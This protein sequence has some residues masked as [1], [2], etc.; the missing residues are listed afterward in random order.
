MSHML[1]GILILITF[2]SY[3]GKSTGKGGLGIWMH[4]LNASIFIENYESSYYTGPAFRFGAG[5][6]AY[7]AYIAADAK[8]YRVIGGECPTVG[9]VGGYTQGG[10][11]SML[12]SLYGL[13]A[14]QTLEWEVVTAQG[15]HLKATPN[16]NS[17]LYWALSGGGGGTFGVVLSMTVRA[18][19]D[20]VVGGAS[21]SLPL[22]TL[23]NDTFW[24]AVAHFH[25]G[26]AP[27]VDAGISI[28]YSVFSDSFNVISLTSPNAT[29]TKV[30]SQLEYFTHYLDDH[31]VSYTLNTTSFSRYLDHVIHYFGPLPDG[32]VP[33]SSLIGSRLIPRSTV[34]ADRSDSNLTNALKR[35]VATPPFYAVGVA[36]NVSDKNTI[37]ANAVLPAWRDALIHMTI[38]GPWDYTGSTQELAAFEDTL[39]NELN[40]VLDAVAPDSGTYVN[41]ANFQLGSWK[42]SFYGLNY[43]ELRDVKRRYD[44][45]NL[46]Y[47]TKAVGSEEWTVDGE[48]RL[49]RA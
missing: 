19:R 44:P 39:T 24:A 1:N 25:A 10:G 49:C 34:Q 36:V 15:Q 42:E 27:L 37:A 41:E 31:N 18:H 32:D 7:E 16:E 30:R 11:H 22:A 12:S 38:I 26:I 29:A 6:L 33:A 5:I 23:S 3:L 28:I 45:K 17:D 2:T 4:S 35:I 8:G 48:G 21:L 40:P 43:G 46:L 13:G 20:S 47:A 14:D 9:I